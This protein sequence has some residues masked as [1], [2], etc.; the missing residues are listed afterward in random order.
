MKTTYDIPSSQAHCHLCQS[1]SSKP[2]YH[3]LKREVRGREDS[4]Q[5]LVL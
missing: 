2:G 5:L 1:H 4:G 3:Q